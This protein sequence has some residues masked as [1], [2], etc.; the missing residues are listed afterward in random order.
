MKPQIYFT[1]FAESPAKNK[2]KR[3]FHGELALG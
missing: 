3:F 2:K 1:C